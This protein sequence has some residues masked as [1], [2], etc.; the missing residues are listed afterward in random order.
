MTYPPQNPC[1]SML[2]KL[3]KKWWMPKL[4]ATSELLK[5]GSIY[6]KTGSLEPA[7]SVLL[8]YADGFRTF[9]ARFR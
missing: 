9:L 5:N 2:P 1:D 4:N 6:K 3:R 7:H 8:A